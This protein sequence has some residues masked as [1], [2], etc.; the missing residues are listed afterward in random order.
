MGELHTGPKHQL[1]DADPSPTLTSTWY[2]IETN[3][4]ERA[5][6]GTWYSITRFTLGGWGSL[7][8]IGCPSKRWE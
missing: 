2:P 1:S 6:A 4:K 3:K 5:T 7:A 8:L